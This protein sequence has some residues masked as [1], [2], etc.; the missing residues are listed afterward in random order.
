MLGL[1]MSYNVYQVDGS[2]DGPL[3]IYSSKKKA[4]VAAIAYVVSNGD[5]NYTID[6]TSWSTVTSVANDG[7]QADVTQWKVK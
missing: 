2:H 5:D 7:N 4:I 3:G 6:D 1:K